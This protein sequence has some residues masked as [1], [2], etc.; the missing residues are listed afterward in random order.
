MKLSGCLIAFSPNYPLDEACV[1]CSQVMTVFG[2]PY[3]ALKNDH[4][5][6]NHLVV[7]RRVS[8]NP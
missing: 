7:I 3:S 1:A 5:V 6:V 2:S 8:D 4:L